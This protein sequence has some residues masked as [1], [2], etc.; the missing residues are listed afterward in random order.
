MTQTQT[1]SDERIIRRYEYEDGWTVVADLGVADE[2][3]DV[4]TVSE[5]A[6]VV[7][8]IDNDPVKF[9]LELPAPAAGVTTNNGVLTI[10]G[11][12]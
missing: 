7:I 1:G 10:E 11:N 4:D 12:L 8:E 3:V 6:I 5:T 2:R 9:E